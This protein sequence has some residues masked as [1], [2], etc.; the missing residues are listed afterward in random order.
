MI[1]VNP[2]SDSLNEELRDC[3]HRI[4]ELEDEVKKLQEE[5]DLLKRLNVVLNNMLST[6]PNPQIELDKVELD[7]DDE[8]SGYKCVPVIPPTTSTS[9]YD[10]CTKFPNITSVSPI[11]YASS[12]STADEQW[13]ASAD[14]AGPVYG[15]ADD[16]TYCPA[17]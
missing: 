15:V 9:I 17:N 13:K 3:W 8:T 14:A 7:K 5:N 16:V 6:L 11:Q 10:F 2:F 4:E 1:E 12:C